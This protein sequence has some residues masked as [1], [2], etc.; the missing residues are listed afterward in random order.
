MIYD[1]H[2]HLPSP[3]SGVT[4]EW[5]PHTPDVPSAIRYLR[6]CGIDH[7]LA[8]TA[9]GLEAKT[10]Q[11]M[12][13]GNDEIASIASE[14][15]DFVV[16]T[17]Q[18]NTNFHQEA[19][20]EV[21]RCH[22]KLNMI[23]VGELC[24]YAGEYSYRTPAFADM[25]HLATRLNMI[26]NFHEDDYREVERICQAFPDT[27]LV[28]AHLADTPEDTVNRI[29]LAQRYPNLYLDI[30]GWGIE[31]MGVLEHAVRMAGPDRVLFGSDFTINDP[32]SV[33][34]RVEKS[35]L[36]EETKEK[37]LGGN[38]VRLL[39]EHGWTGR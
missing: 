30:C 4:L 15:P 36:D 31:R 21:R 1:C 28:L 27:T 16:P 14:Y 5:Q 26:V 22:D 20:I 11:D 17:C 29:G 18:V 6:R 32:A 38:L 3:R 23:W 9:L 37:I 12:I 8:S 33:I 19:L 34:A 10:H 39:K 24:A 7:I 35:Y 2:V 25:V 13:A